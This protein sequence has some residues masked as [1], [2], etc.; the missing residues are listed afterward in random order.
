MYLRFSVNNSPLLKVGIR[1]AT[2]GQSCWL[3]MLFNPYPLKYASSLHTRQFLKLQLFN[4]K[5]FVYRRVYPRAHQ[6]NYC[7][8]VIIETILVG[9]DTAHRQEVGELSV[10][11]DTSLAVVAV[12]ENQV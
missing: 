2:V 4:G 3:L 10:Q 5:P 11:Q 6:V 7:R 1:T 12:Y 9:Y 8:V